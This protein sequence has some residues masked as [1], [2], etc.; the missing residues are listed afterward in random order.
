MHTEV[1][2]KISKDD[3]PCG[4]FYLVLNYFTGKQAGSVKIIDTS[5]H[6][7]V[8]NSCPPNTTE[9]QKPLKRFP[10]LFS[11]FFSS[12]WHDPEERCV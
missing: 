10:A 1:A 11:L 3:L 9:G 7:S 4:E 8:L 6:D 12:E 5:V 2:F